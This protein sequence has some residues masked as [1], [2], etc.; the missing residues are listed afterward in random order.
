MKPAKFGLPLAATVDR[1]GSSD[2]VAPNTITVTDQGRVTSL[3]KMATYNELL[4]KKGIYELLEKSR[5]SQLKAMGISTL[6]QKK[7]AEIDLL[8]KTNKLNQKGR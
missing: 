6:T 5:A 7:A 4:K 2:I 8:V 1:G 3:S